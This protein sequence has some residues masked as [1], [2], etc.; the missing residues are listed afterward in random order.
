M[1]QKQMEY[2][3]FVITQKNNVVNLQNALDNF[4]ALSDFRMY[5]HIEEELIS[6][7]KKLIE[8]VNKSEDF[9]REFDEE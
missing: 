4:E 6:L 3:N 5:C 8:M 7:R 1:E 2:N 9:V